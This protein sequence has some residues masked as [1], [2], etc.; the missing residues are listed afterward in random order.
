MELLKFED[1][2]VIKRYGVEP[3]PNS[4]PVAETETETEP[5]T[6]SDEQ[7][8]DEDWDEEEGT[9]ITIYEGAC[10]YEEAGTGFYYP[11][12]EHN[13]MVFLPSNDVLIEVND[14]VS[15][16]TFKGRT[17]KAYVESVRDVKTP[18]NAREVTRITL[19]ENI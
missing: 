10:L 8:E 2:C 14:E 1:S 11:V 9:G 6:E 18:L 7:D 13:A 5:V 3:P 19:K 16:T 15:I 12:Q 4:E 17:R